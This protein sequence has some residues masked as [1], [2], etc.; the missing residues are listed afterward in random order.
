[1]KKYINKEV[2]VLI[3]HTKIGDLY[4]GHTKNYIVVN[5]KGDNLNNKI[6]KTYIVKEENLELIG[7]INKN[8]N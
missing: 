4:K 2:E 6:L 1:L 8:N 7:E 5:V 3:E